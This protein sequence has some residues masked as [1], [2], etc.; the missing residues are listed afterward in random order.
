MSRRQE[1]KR[2]R[3]RERRGEFDTLDLF[4]PAYPTVREEEFLLLP[5]VHLPEA[6][7]GRCHEFV[8]DGEAGR[9]TCLHPA[10]GV[11]FPWYD[12]GACPFFRGA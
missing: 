12:T 2:R 4:A 7:C 1:R 9:G 11:M 8:E 5:V 6:R 10:S 3:S